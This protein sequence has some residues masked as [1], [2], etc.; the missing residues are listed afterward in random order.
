MFAQQIEKI[1]YW[2][3]AWLAS[4]HFWDKKWSPLRTKALQKQQTKAEETERRGFWE[5]GNNCITF[6]LYHFHKICITFKLFILYHFAKNWIY[7]ILF[8]SYNFVNKCI[9][10]ASLSH[11]YNFARDSI[12]FLVYDFCPKSTT[13]TKT[14]VK[15]VCVTPLTQALPERALFS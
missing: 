11:L 10:I 9:S 3:V 6:T 5:L 4:R 12:V 2:T 15:N 1:I 14:F 13:F 7:A 8:T